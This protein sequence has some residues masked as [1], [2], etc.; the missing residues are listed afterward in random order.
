MIDRQLLIFDVSSS[1]SILNVF[2][3]AEVHFKNMH[4]VIAVVVRHQVSLSIVLQPQSGMVTKYRNAEQDKFAEKDPT[5]VFIADAFLLR[6]NPATNMVILVLIKNP[7]KF[8]LR[9]VLLSPMLE[10]RGNQEIVK[11]V[12][13]SSRLPLITT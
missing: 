11:Y 13:K 5:L 1:S 7:E 9:V 6:E 8:R 10:C 3:L 4:W 12:G 2:S